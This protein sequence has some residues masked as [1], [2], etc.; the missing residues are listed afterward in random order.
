MYTGSRKWIARAMAARQAVNDL[1]R[2]LEEHLAGK[3]VSVPK[4]NPIGVQT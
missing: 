1:D 2:A 3:P 4:T